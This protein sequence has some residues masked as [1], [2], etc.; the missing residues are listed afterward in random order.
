MTTDPIDSGSLAAA[1]SRRAG[2]QRS[3]LSSKSSNGKKVVAKRPQAAE[4]F[5]ERARVRPGRGQ[6][7]EE[8]QGPPVHEHEAARRAPIA[9]GKEQNGVRRMEIR[10]M[11]GTQEGCSTAARTVHELRRK[12]RSLVAA[13]SCLLVILAA[14]SLYAAAG[15]R[16]ERCRNNLAA[17][18]ELGAPTRLTLLSPMKC[19]FSSTWP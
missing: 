9:A 13:T 10:M 4:R 6:G 5:S 1:R 12:G 3:L 2:P 8:L 15:R 17:R 18:H 19:D 7:R 11:Q 16:K 14:I